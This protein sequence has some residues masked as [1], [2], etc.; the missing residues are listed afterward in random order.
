MNGDSHCHRWLIGLRRFPSVIGMS[1][2]A[3]GDRAPFH[4]GEN[5]HA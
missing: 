3:L 2:I 5:N 1:E 4:Q